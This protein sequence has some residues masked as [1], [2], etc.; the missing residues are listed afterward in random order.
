M[1]PFAS[2][3]VARFAALA[4]CAFGAGP[5]LTYTGALRALC[6]CS[7]LEP[8][9]MSPSVVQS[10]WLSKS[11]DGAQLYCDTHH[12][13][14]A[15]G[16]MRRQSKLDI[17]IHQQAPRHL[18]APQHPS[19]AAVRGHGGGGRKRNR[20]TLA[21]GA[22]CGAQAPRRGWALRPFGVVFAL[23]SGFVRALCH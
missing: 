3:C 20:G 10:T 18:H 6:Q 9:H 22:T 2:N 11:G 17:H 19:K 15:R 1:V 5:V 7:R 4:P 13:S 23:P 21:R 14:S 16:T 12:Q 8:A